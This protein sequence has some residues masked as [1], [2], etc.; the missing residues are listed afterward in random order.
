[1]RAL[2]ATYHSDGIRGL[3]FVPDIVL[4][5]TGVGSVLVDVLEIAAPDGIVCLTGV[6]SGGHRLPIDLGL[7]NR[8]IVL[9]NTVVFGS[10]NA[11]RAHYQAAA[12]ALAKADQDWLARLLS[13][14]VPL[15]RFADALVRKPGDVKVVIDFGLP[16]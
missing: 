7:V 1:M 15:D 13:R 16:P 8:E 9:E 10:V 5:C 2:G 4:E 6:S 12:S 3:G 11:N 14:R